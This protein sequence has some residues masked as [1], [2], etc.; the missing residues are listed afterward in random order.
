[1]KVGFT[2]T[3]M[4]MTVAQAEE[5]T[6]QLHRAGV[7]EFHHGD[8]RGADEQAHGCA[9]SLGVT[10][11]G[12]PPTGNGLRAWCECDELREPAAY[13]TRNRNI[14]LET[15]LLI[16]TPDGPERSRSGTW[17]TV[18]YAR[19][20]SAPWIVIHPNGTVDCADPVTRPGLF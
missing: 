7:T 4:G 1:M 17:S 14:V 16:A 10:I 9:R 20:L 12:H 15:Q 19:R 18:R 8:C 13:L 2:G 6:R 11:V 3:R 5:L